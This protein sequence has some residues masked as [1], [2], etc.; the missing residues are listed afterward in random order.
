MS[1]AAA[2]S[3]PRST[4]RCAST[5]RSFEPGEPIV[6]VLLEPSAES[7]ADADRFDRLDYTDAAW[8]S[9]ARPDGS[10]TVFAVWHA[11]APEPGV[12]QDPL[13]SPDGLMDLFEQLEGT[14]DPRRR[15]FRYVLALQLMRKRRLEYIGT[16]DH[17]L[18]VRVRGS[19]EEEAPMVV[20]D[21]QAAG[22]L[23]EAALAD[24]AEQVATLM[25]GDDGR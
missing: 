18:L 25:D 13:I 16:Q 23:D 9:G 1:T 24:L 12:K 5:G 4:L 10:R 17:A 22:E 2:F 7:E 19:A 21:P 11:S 8:S 20:H 6:V 15:A 14:D 3:I